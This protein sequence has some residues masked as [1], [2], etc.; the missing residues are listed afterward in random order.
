MPYDKLMLLREML[1]ISTNYRFL[2]IMLKKEKIFAIKQYGEHFDL[3]LGFWK[4]SMDVRI[5]L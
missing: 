3:N 4:E 2:K 5:Q 1:L